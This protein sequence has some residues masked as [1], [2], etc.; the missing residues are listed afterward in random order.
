MHVN[1]GT[2]D[3][4]R[5]LGVHPAEYEMNFERYA[6][7]VVIVIIGLL[8]IGSSHAQNG[9]HPSR[10]QVREGG[11]K[12]WAQDIPVNLGMQ[13][14]KRSRF[15]PEGIYGPL[16]TTLMQFNAWLLGAYATALDPRASRPIASGDA[17]PLRQ[18]A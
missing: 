5:W 14:G 1:D 10:P 17:V 4:L 9:A 11:G 15:A 2:T 12:I 13:A 6:W 7:I 8:G 16:K 3:A 18:R